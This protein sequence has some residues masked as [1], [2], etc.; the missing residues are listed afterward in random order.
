MASASSFTLPCKTPFEVFLSFRRPDTGESFTSH[1]YKALSDEN[2]QTFIDKGLERG[3][4]IESSLLKA[5]E[6]SEISVIVFSKG[7]A[8]SPWCL[9][10]LVKILECRRTMGQIVLPIFY[11]VGSS[12]MDSERMKNSTWRA[13]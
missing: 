9:D 11:R 3:K 7:Y 2:I 1:L 5:I 10:E 4:E 8:S 6:E 13:R 12:E